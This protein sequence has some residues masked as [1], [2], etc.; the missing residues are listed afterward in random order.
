MHNFIFDYSRI[1]AGAIGADFRDNYDSD[2]FGSEKKRPFCMKECLRELLARL[3]LTSAGA[4]RQTMCSGLRFV[5]PH[6]ADLEWLYGKLADDE[7]RQILASVIAFRALGHRKIRLSRNSPT[8]WASL[9]KA[10]NIAQGREELDAGFLGWKL[11]KCDLRSL[12]Y[13]IKLFTFP[14]GCVEMFALEQYRC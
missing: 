9:R 11:Y 1:L 10:E 5:E 12:G 8:Y 2:R 14:R 3:G 7:S 13:P 4:A 6:L